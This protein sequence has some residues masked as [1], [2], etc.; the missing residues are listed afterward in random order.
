MLLETKEGA[1]VGESKAQTRIAHLLSQAQRA[2]SAEGQ[3]QPFTEVTGLGRDCP[4][5]PAQLGASDQ[6]SLR[7]CF[8]WSPHFYLQDPFFS[9]MCTALYGFIILSI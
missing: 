9:H 4:P 2:G 1:K 3:S 7:G 6:I 8:H 5:H